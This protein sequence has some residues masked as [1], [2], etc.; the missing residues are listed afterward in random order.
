MS[1]YNLYVLAESFANTTW[2]MFRY[3]NSL[4][5][6]GFSY[7]MKYLFINSQYNATYEQQYYAG[8]SFANLTQYYI[9]WQNGSNSSNSSN[10]SNTTNSSTI[11]DLIFSGYLNET[12]QNISN[13]TS[14]NLSGYQSIIFESMYSLSTNGFDFNNID[15]Y[16][17]FRVMIY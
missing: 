17:S 9:N 13:Q 3:N 14:W 11:D 8:L 10:S 2:D 1:A 16:E 15:D 6:E 4:S 5:P 7:Y 12:F